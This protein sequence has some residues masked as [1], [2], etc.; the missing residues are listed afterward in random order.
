VVPIAELGAKE[1]ERSSAEGLVEIPP[2]VLSRVEA[3]YDA[4]LCLQAYGEAIK[5]GPL[6]RW[7]GIPARVLAGR[8]AAN[9][10]AYRLNRVQHWL[11]W[12]S[13]KTNPELLAYHGYTIFQ[14]RGPLGAFEFLERHREVKPTGEPKGL[15]HYYTLRAMVSGHLRDFK[16]SDYW[17]SQAVEM[18]PEDAWVA[19]T[20]ADILE[21]QDRYE[22][23]LE[24]ARHALALRP[25]YRP[26]VQ[27]LAHGLQLLDRDEEALEFLTA[28]AKHLENMH[29]VRQL[30]GLQQ[31]LGQY[32]EAGASLQRLAE[33][34]PL[35]E[36]RERVWLQRQ[37][38]ALDCLRNNTAAALAA[39]K[40][41]DEPYY[42]ELAKRLES[43]GPFRRV[44]LEVP[45]VRQ[46]HMTCSP[47]TLSAISGYWR[48]P[49]AHLEVAEKICYNGTPAHS[50]R[51]WAETNGWATRE[52]TV[53]WEAAVALLDRK[54]PF[55]LT[56]SG[57]TSGHLQAVIGYDEARQTLWIRD[58]FLYS[59]SEF[60]IKSLL[61]GQRSTGPRGMALVPAECRDLLSGL[62][63]P[64]AALYDQLH[65][66]ERA[67][68]QHHRD[69]AIEASKAM[70]AR[71]A[72]HRLTLS[73]QRAI[74]SYDGNT[75]A[76]LQ[77][78]ELLLKQ[79]PN[80]GNLNLTKLGCLKE[81][82]RRKERLELLELISAKAGTD[83]VFWQ[84]YARELRLDAREHRAAASWV[85]WALRYRPLD[86]MLISTW[87]DLL[88]DKREFESATRYYRL[89]ACVGDK[90]EDFAQK[91]FIA[92]RHLK[93][94]E[95]ALEF[96]KERE[97]RLRK[98]S[99]D[100]SIAL[101]QALQQL[102]RSG[103]AFAVLDSALA[104]SP[105]PGMLRLFA[106]DFYGRFSRF[107]EAEGFLQEAQE[108][109][110]GARWH[111]TAAALAGYQNQKPTALSH[112][113]EV[114]KLEP[115]SHDAIRA[116]AL[117]L[118][119]TEGRD[120]A[121]RFLVELC[122]RFPFSCPLLRLRIEWLAQDEAAVCIPHLR[123][124]LEVNPADGWGWRELAIR[125]DQNGK[126]AEAE[127]AAE[128]AIRL[129]PRHSAGYCVRGDLHRHAGRLDEAHRDYGEA[130]R[131]EIDNEHALGSFVETAESL[132][133]RRQ[134]LT[135]VTEELR[136]QVIFSGALYAYQT[137]ARG[138]L[139]AGEVL[140]L[141]KEAHKARPD[142]W[143]AWSVLVGE[144][145]NAGH[146]E[147]A[148]ALS[149]ESTERFP[150]LPRLWVD[151]CRVEQARLNAAG[152]IAALE[153]ALELSPGYAFAARQL[154]GIFER[155]GELARA[156]RTL[157][158]AISC[159]PLDPL[160]HGCLAETFWKLGK[161][162]EAISKLRHALRLEPG[163]DWAWNALRDWGATI[164][165]PTLAAEL[166]RELTRT[167][168]GETRSWLRLAG[169]LQA[170]TDG[171]E[172][173]GALER[174][175]AL[176][177]RSELAF[178]ARARAL[179]RLNRFDEALAQCAPAIYQAVPIQLAIRA[180][181][182]EAQRGNLGKAIE[183]AKAALAEHPEYI[184]GWQLLADWHVRNQD[185]E[186]ATQSAEK[187]VSLAPL[188]A[189][190]L[191]YLGDL[192]LRL[193]DQ[194][195]ARRAFER[196][197]TLDPDYTYAG[198]Q[199]FALLLT[200]REG[201][202]AEKTLKIL[203]RQGETHQ[204][205]SCGVE[206]ACARGL[207][208]K[209]VEQFG[210]LCDLPQAEGWSIA[211]AAQA[212]DL[213]GR[214]QEVDRELEKQLAGKAHRPAPVTYW[215]ERKVTRGKWGLHRWLA[216]LPAA[217]EVRRS[218]VLT[219]LDL[220]GQAFQ[221]VRQ[222]RDLSKQLHLRY[223]FWR[224]LRR[225]RSWLREDV[226]GWGKV[227]YVLSTIGR[228]GPVI[229]WLGDWKNR[230]KAQSWMLYNL[231]IML[232]HKKRYEE[233]REI[234][235]HAVNLRHGEELHDV[236][237]LWAAFEEG[238]LGNPG[239]AKA[240]LAALP[241]GFSPASLGP[242]RTLTEILID[243]HEAGSEKG[244]LFESIKSRLKEAFGKLRP[245]QSP[246]YVRA[247]YRRFMRA[248][249]K[250]VDG[251]SFWGWW[252]YR[253]YEWLGLGLLL[254]M[255]LLMV[256]FGFAVSPLLIALM[257]Y[258]GRRSFNK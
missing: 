133:E 29:V 5:A 156:H 102:G 21:C 26:G 153:K 214:R 216:G 220:M 97:R 51:N 42:Q 154:A 126:Q 225:H 27:A 147:E 45:F 111:L 20:R 217:S 233:S 157:E 238:L 30:S 169:C 137:A 54:I 136:R 239:A 48:R 171:E 92:S 161:R 215:I 131:L 172:L 96:L 174:A 52:F 88:W 86:S 129:E 241:A 244:R 73:G 234:I 116:I 112:W 179:T 94:T 191:G 247:G 32:E 23:A 17:L 143:Q 211:K 81:L 192:K 166:A 257:I 202:A 249:A 142:L 121:L 127:E 242:V 11:A 236:F 252:F 57:A 205:I 50:E 109:S 135:V 79:F 43:G 176:N 187:M 91:L 229:A 160:N 201:D 25:W 12:R 105:E 15:A 64:D 246:R 85:R 231:V 124:L 118:A 178:D 186:S 13:D 155:E 181:W 6:S 228:P 40:R 72:E 150:L 125:L 62:E 93:R 132:S 170:E 158:A 212:L 61:E 56:T 196:A 1:E 199:L 115:L 19:T 38:I 90:N 37:Q 227:G 22:E 134:A 194:E 99:I 70:Q 77:C 122:E 60:D 69:E 189:V 240:H 152:E 53:T 3:L 113:R 78:I 46:H 251:L 146:L 177:P 10:G 114:L 2:E 74:A 107:T 185:F 106:A 95:E 130:L 164:G 47:A 100:P 222:R 230:P 204:T 103:E 14:R 248:A 35:I 224:L 18:C 28:A 255:V 232:Q 68:A 4:G 108:A 193:G 208:K 144:L 223:H 235:R 188:E 41:L 162:E 119:E 58:P 218:A 151:R 163:Y 180:A 197:F 168:A 140:S 39:A 200:R 173:F 175:Q 128:E 213:A 253:G 31:E 59:T 258:F 84:Q 159:S 149:K 145:V 120:A 87:A 167:R 49:A 219:Y 24:S 210:A 198:I 101:V 207:L 98:K 123:Q 183:R 7:S 190:P 83:P 75:P 67:L 44:L 16:T 148:L 195:G 76:L 36:K 33:L 237:R 141:L 110:P 184:A 82:A 256:P 254:A 80:D 182:V 117:L 34:A 226:E 104:Q 209:A 165:K 65:R 89:A 63:L 71:A 203:A 138:V 66:I 139:A 245:C 221:K 8:L 243:I 55:T 9:L 250:E 206:L